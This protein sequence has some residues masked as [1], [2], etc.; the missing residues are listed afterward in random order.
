MKTKAIRALLL[1]A[2]DALFTQGCNTMQGHGKDI[3]TAGDE[4]EYA[5]KK[6]T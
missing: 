5:S 1:A 3:E 2:P 4:L 6:S